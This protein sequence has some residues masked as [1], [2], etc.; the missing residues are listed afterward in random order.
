MAW[1]S[2]PLWP[3]T[4]PAALIQSLRPSFPTQ[5]LLLSSSLRPEARLLPTL[6][7]PSPALGPA[8][9]ADLAFSC[10]W[11]LLFLSS[12]TRSPRTVMI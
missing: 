6:A 4:P 12:M 9:T 2:C 10:E 8:V 5:D 1:A 11:A 7:C 3:L